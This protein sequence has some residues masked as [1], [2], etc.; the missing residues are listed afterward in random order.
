M[1]N[2]L[3]EMVGA[4]TIRNGCVVGREK[5]GGENFWFRGCVGRADVS[6]IAEAGPS[7]FG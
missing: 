6:L 3:M 2:I 7:I 1:V 4:L 5:F